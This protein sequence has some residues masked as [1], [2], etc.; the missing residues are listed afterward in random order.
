M[1]EIQPIAKELKAM[2]IS[3]KKEKDQEEVLKMP[4]LEI[5]K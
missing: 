1:Q 2:G 3:T 5:G 4:E